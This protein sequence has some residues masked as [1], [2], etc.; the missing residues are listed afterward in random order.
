[1]CGD[2]YYN[3]VC[4]V[5]GS[6]IVSLEQA[7]HLVVAV[8]DQVKASLKPRVLPS[9]NERRRQLHTIVSTTNNDQQ[10][11]SVR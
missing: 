11:L 7:L 6:M 8:Y 2:R 10:A 9:F 4:V 5:R 3:H 1:M